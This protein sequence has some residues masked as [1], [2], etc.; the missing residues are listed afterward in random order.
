MHYTFVQHE[1]IGYL[2]QAFIMY[3]IIYKLM[4][5]W[6]HLQVQNKGIAMQQNNICTCIMKL[7][8]WNDVL[9]LIFIDIQVTLIEND[10][11]GPTEITKDIKLNI[12][13][14]NT[15][16]KT[17]P[18]QKMLSHVTHKMTPLWIISYHVT[19]A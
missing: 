9:Q 3:Q 6:Y 7:K 16:D 14:W 13:C 8:T 18:N 4:Y 5:R 19:L 12:N 11:P 2:S 1:N 15:G 10:T 17:W